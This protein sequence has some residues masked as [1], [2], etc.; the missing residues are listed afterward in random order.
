VNADVSVTA[1]LVSD[2]KKAYK[3]TIHS[4]NDRSLWIGLT[5][6]RSFIMGTNDAVAY[7]QSGEAHFK[8][9]NHSMAITDLT[10]SIKSDPNNARAYCLRG[11]VR[12]KSLD[13]DTNK[14]IE[15]FSQ[16]IRL[17]PDYVVAYVNRASAYAKIDDFDAAVQDYKKV[18]DLDPKNLFAYAGCARMYEKLGF[19]E[20][21]ID[22]YGKAIQIAPNDTDLLI[23]RATLYHAMGKDNDKMGKYGDAIGNYNDAIADCTKVIQIDPTNA[24]AYC[25]RGFLH[26]RSGDLDS[27]IADIEKALKL[28]PNYVEAK[29]FLAECSRK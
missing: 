2:S 16:A 20:D 10:Q 1:V 13:T 8:N 11:L 21:A 12:F 18:I 5:E 27:A 23:Y 14:E 28:D 3:P 19:P 9:G 25:M 17:K 4:R 24:N 7:F 22:I 29:S 15:D 6:K 26:K